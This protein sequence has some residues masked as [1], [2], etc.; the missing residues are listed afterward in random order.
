[1]VSRTLFIEM[2]TPYSYRISSLQWKFARIRNFRSS[3]KGDEKKKEKAFL[4]PGLTGG[5]I[6]SRVR[7][8]TGMK[9]GNS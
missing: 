3:R 5:V 6:I 8:R 2:R 4:S 1:M 7:L 9:A